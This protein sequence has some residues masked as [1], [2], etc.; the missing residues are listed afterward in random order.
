MMPVM[1]VSRKAPVV[2]LDVCPSHCDEPAVPL[3]ALRGRVSGREAHV[4]AAELFRLLGDPT[5]LAILHALLEGGEL[6]VCDLAE[7]LGMGQSA[8][9]HQL[10]ILRTAG[11]HNIALFGAG[12]LGQAIASSDIFADH[13]F[14]VVAIFDTD[15]GTTYDVVCGDETG[16]LT[17]SYA[18]APIP[19]LDNAGG[20]FAGLA[21]G[22]GFFVLS[23]L[24]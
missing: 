17:G 24:L 13:G 22:F 6:C 20:I 11:Q 5:R 4:E 1:A 14:R 8:I 21:A 10:R 19:S 9:S 16:T 18:V 7:L 2:D 23:P 12:H 3:D 15:P